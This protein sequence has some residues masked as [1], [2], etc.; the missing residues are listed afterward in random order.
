MTILPYLPSY[1]PALLRLFDLNC[2]EYFHPS[3]KAHFEHYL[4]HETEDYFIAMNGETALGCAGLN[5]ESDQ[6]VAILSWDMIHPSHHG[7]GIGRKLVEHRLQRMKDLP[8]IR[9][10]IVRTSQ[11][12]WVFY[13]KMGFELKE[14]KANYWAPG[15]D[16][17][18]MEM[19]F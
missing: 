19:S 16:L 18:Y 4:G 12:T 6:T 13:Q 15:M 1:K 7:E 8:G 11:H 2:P 17:Y 10:I 3:E 5:Y 14:R 9:N